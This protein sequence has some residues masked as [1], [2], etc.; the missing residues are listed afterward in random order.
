MEKGYSRSPGGGIRRSSQIL[1]SLLVSNSSYYTQLT[2]SNQL[3]GASKI[4]YWRDLRASTRRRM[5]KI[6]GWWKSSHW[7][8]WHLKC[9]EGMQSSSRAINVIMNQNTIVSYRLRSS[10]LWSRG[11]W[12]LLCFTSESEA[13]RRQRLLLQ[14]LMDDVNSS[15]TW[16]RN[17]TLNIAYWGRQT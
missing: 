11:E 17:T 7:L 16:S 13:T 9:S 6:W 10:R 1:Y 15:T 5:D 14:G 8:S 2:M 3:Q 12:K 4:E